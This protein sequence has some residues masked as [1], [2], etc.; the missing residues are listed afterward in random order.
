MD[1]IVG[2]V[3][4][5]LYPLARQRG[6]RTLICYQLGSKRARLTFRGDTEAAKKHCKS[7]LARDVTS[8]EAID[9]LHLTALDRR[10]YITA[11]ATAAKIGRPV[12]AICR[13]SLEAQQILGAGASLL[14]A[15]RDWKRRHAAGYPRAE[16]SQ[17]VE[18]LLASLQGKRRDA[19]T[20]KSLRIPLRRLAQHIRVP[21]AEVQTL[22]LERWLGL[23]PGNAPRTTNNW[24]N[25]IVRLF[26]YAKGR[27]L[28]ADS[29]TVADA[30]EA[31]TDDR[32][33]RPVA[34]YQPWELSAL[35]HHA[36]THLRFLIALGAFAGI[37]TK[38]LHRLDWSHIH[39]A[40]L[41]DPKAV[42]RPSQ[43]PPQK[44]AE[45]PVPYP[46]GFIEVPGHLAKQ[47][48]TAARRIV[49]IQPNLAAW[50]DDARLL[51]GR[52]SKYAEDKALS[53]AVTTLTLRLNA[54][55]K[56]HRLP[57]ISRPDNGARHSYG[58]Y[59]LPLIGNVDLLALEMNNSAAE[60]IR[61][62]RELVHPDRVP[63]YWAIVPK[64]AAS[65]EQIEFAPAAGF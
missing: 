49:P 46:H 9:A 50:L 18:E 45:P 55:R 6:A 51:T 63:E 60:I 41:P 56:K 36:P 8:G 37:R 27:Y 26:N 28:T 13:E 59:R 52:V 39:L 38:E 17:V 3:R 29:R 7:T 1:H 20:V 43:T 57:A 47:H 23:Y 10:I 53:A 25:A 64:I 24:I 42:G 14:E 30:L 35:L 19:S 11:K 33:A 12:D 40:A 58:S 32:R 22:E 54:Q 2:G 62:Y 4:F 48:R 65:I 61:D 5:Q 31:V 21:I 15:A 44:P 34:I 16:L